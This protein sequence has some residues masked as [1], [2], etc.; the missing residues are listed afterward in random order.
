MYE[1]LTAWFL[2]LA[3]NAT[4]GDPQ[5]ETGGDLARLGAVPGRGDAVGTWVASRLQGVAR[6]WRLTGGRVREED[7]AGAIWKVVTPDLGAPVK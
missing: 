5:P 3:G 7:L 2:S 6:D 4:P 1:G